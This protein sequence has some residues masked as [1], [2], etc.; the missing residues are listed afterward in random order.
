[1]IERFERSEIGRCHLHRAQVR[2]L[3]P[4]KGRNFL[5]IDR[6]QIKIADFGKDGV[7]SHEAASDQI[8]ASRAI[9]WATL[10]SYAVN[11]SRVC[12]R[13]GKAFANIVNTI[14]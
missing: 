6:L 5:L 4:E 2:L 14:G 12:E 13:E 3:R 11:F 10:R 9:L 7:F 8:H 1:M